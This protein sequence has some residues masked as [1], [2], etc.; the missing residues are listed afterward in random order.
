M[1][2]DKEHVELLKDFSE[3]GISFDIGKI[4]AT[5]LPYL[6]DGVQ[7]NLTSNGFK[8]L[9]KITEYISKQIPFTKDNAQ[10]IILRNV[11]RGNTN[12]IPVLESIRSLEVEFNESIVENTIILPVI[13]IAVDAPFKIG[14]FT[15]FKKHNCEI[16]N[17]I[18]DPLKR[19]F[20]EKS[21]GDY[22]AVGVLMGHSSSCINLGK[23]VL[24]IELT[25]FKAF[26]PL[27]A[28]GGLKYWIANMST[29]VVLVDAAIIINAEGLGSN[30]SLLTNPYGLN[31]DKKPNP[32]A[33]SFREFLSSIGFD[34]LVRYS[35]SNS[36]YENSINM[37]FWWLGKQ[38]D[39]DSK[40]IK[41]LYSVLALEKLLS[42]PTSFSSISAAVAEKCAFLL[43][44]NYDE[45]F[46]IFKKA[47]ELYKVRSGLTHGS[48][49]EETTEADVKIA[50]SLGINVLLRIIDL[51]REHKFSSVADL[52]SYINKIKFA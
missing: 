15:I 10:K 19:T 30:Y 4:D 27:I 41:L 23:K 26:L 40:E 47:K 37:A 33:K 20:I 17:N 5:N 28:D 35:A 12:S 1:K 16:L 13:G 32:E 38:A 31:I 22:V 52:D 45:R 7:Y 48:T 29:N 36:K 46:K 43:A 3:N 34:E 14:T 42:N 50:H 8:I 39:E 6:M 25:R 44:S 18:Q 2:F 24:E 51:N 11:I 49:S 9:D 21:F